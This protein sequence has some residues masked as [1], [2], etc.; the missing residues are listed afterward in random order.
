M[1]RPSDKNKGFETFLDK[2]S[3]KVYG[4]SRTESIRNNICLGCGEPA[5]EFKD[6]ISEKEYTISG[7]CQVCQDKVFGGEQ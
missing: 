4:R 5:V 6:S 3:L 1:A 2:Y 7:F